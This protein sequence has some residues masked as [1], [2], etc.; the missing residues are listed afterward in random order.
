LLVSAA[1]ITGGW[2][3]VAVKNMPVGSLVI[4]VDLAPIKPIRGV[5]TLLGDITTHKCR[6]AIRK[7]ANG[8]LMDVVLH[9]GTLA[10]LCCTSGGRSR[11][12]NVLLAFPAQPDTHVH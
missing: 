4:G 11:C 12:G 3:Q 7:E 9:D 6:Q 8:S 1:V 10:R 5:K 2:C